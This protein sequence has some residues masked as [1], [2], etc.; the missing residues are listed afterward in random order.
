M[1]C[2]RPSQARSG[3]PLR[4]ASR[5]PLAYPRTPPELQRWIDT[6]RCFAPPA[7][8]RPRHGQQRR[9]F[10]AEEQLPPN[11]ARRSQIP[12][13]I[14]QPGDANRRTGFLYRF[15]PRDSR[16]SEDSRYSSTFAP[17]KIG[18]ALRDAARLSA[19][20]PS[21]RACERYFVEERRLGQ[22]IAQLAISGFS[23]GTKAE[24]RFPPPRRATRPPG[25]SASSA[26]VTIP[27]VS[28]TGHD[29]SAAVQLRVDLCCEDLNVRVSIAQLMQS[30]RATHETNESDGTRATIL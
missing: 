15:R 27:G 4:I 21:S 18:Q 11:Q 26:K 24:C 25:K 16:I 30:G 13:S 3:E 6:P 23:D 10:P 20:L 17:G 2:G 14:Q 7:A 9:A 8:R 19:S 12:G 22:Q 1:Y 5:L 29:V 28:K